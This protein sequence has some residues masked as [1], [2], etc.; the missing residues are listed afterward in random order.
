MR[1]FIAQWVKVWAMCQRT[2]HSDPT[3][4][5]YKEVH[6][7]QILNLSEPQFHMDKP[8]IRKKKIIMPG[9]QT[10]CISQMKSQ[11]NLEIVRNLEITVKM[12]LKKIDSQICHHLCGLGEVASL[13]RTSVPSLSLYKR[14]HTSGPQPPVC[15]SVRSPACLEWGYTAGG[16]R[17]VSDW[18]K[19][20]LLLPYCSHS[21]LN[22]HCPCPPSMES[23]H[24]TGPWYWNG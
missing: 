9:S 16:E 6:L 3:S 8:G 15:G 2:G 20:L 14:G 24:E 17:W 1:S 11:S 4:T 18:A 12:Q 5:F 22:H 23:V 7:G 13:P 19:L 21:H 10:H